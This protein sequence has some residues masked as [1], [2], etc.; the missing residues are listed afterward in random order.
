V[1][2]KSGYF[3]LIVFWTYWEYFYLNAEISWPWLNLGNAFAN[4]TGIIQWYEY[5]GTLGGTV[6]VLVSNVLLF[7]I[8]KHLITERK[9]RE[10]L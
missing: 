10:G 1:P 8:I 7:G 9:C 6:W 3:A 5:T 4:D 2:G